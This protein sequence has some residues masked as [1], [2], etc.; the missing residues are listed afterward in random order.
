MAPRSDDAKAASAVDAPT[1]R[2]SAAGAEFVYREVGRGDLPPLVALTH[3][4]ANLDGWDPEVIDPLAAERRVILLGYRGVGG[5]T[6]VVRRSFDEAA[7]DAIAV[8][9]VL[10]LERVDLFGLSMG[11]MVAQAILE[12]APE[13]VDRVILAGT[14]PE[15]GAGLTTM[16]GVML[17]SILRGGLTGTDP[18]S[19]L[20]FT[21]SDLGR[22]SAKEYAA[23][24]QR[25][26]AGRDASVG[27]GVFRPQ[28]QA[29]AEWGRRP[30][31]AGPFAAPALILHGDSDRMVPPANVD[32]LRARFAD[33]QVRILHDSGHGVVSQNRRAV[34]EAARDFLRR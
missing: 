23:R 27:L 17:R 2:V 9:R 1:R 21:R 25:R 29:V 7:G 14:G 22:R 20:F 16:A 11:G 18:T 30:V 6:G 15:S 13:L 8:L 34:T 4:G 12:R 33:A 24:L 28:L 26:R 10:G 5:S 32:P 3:L 31:P 19:L